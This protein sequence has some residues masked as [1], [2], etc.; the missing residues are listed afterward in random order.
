M[1][2]FEK[3]SW[4]EQN[5]KWFWLFNRGGPHYTETSQL[6][7]TA[8]RLTDFLW[9]G[10]L[11]N[12]AVVVFYPWCWPMST[13]DGRF[14]YF[15]WRLQK[16]TSDFRTGI[17]F[18]V[19]LGFRRF[20]TILGVGGRQ[21]STSQGITSPP[22]TII[23]TQNSKTQTQNNVFFDMILQNF[24]YNISFDN[25]QQTKSLLEASIKSTET[26]TDVFKLLAS[27]WVKTEICLLGRFWWKSCVAD[28]L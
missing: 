13:V 21:I 18:A 10:A 11:R 4:K 12:E 3:Q 19:L 27:C 26:L 2:T 20:R 22:S 16:R 14:G 28:D 1:R 7:F 17:N 25:T 15:F 24:F 6:I 9:G 5:Y 8:N 23:E